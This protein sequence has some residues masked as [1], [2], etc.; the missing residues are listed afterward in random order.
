[1]FT[2]HFKNLMKTDPI[3]HQFVLDEIERQETS[4][5]LIPSECIASMSTIEALW[6]P[7]T[8]KYSE[9]YANKRYYGGNDV[10]D[11]VEL[12]AIERAKDLFW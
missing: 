11:K 7:F 1:M 8:N 5:E 12:L 4:L 9:W 3:C 6:S 10:V 2:S